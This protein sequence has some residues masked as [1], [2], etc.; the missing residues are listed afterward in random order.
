MLDIRLT[1][2]CADVAAWSLFRGSSRNHSIKD[3]KKAAE[4]LDKGKKVA[5]LVGA[6]ALPATD[7]MIAVASRLNASIANALLR[8]AAVPNDLPCVTGSLGLL[9]TKPSWGS[10]EEVRHLLH[11]RIGVSLR[12]VPAQA[13]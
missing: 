1:T 5:I 2:R 7:E 11:G 6:G 13:W 12:R 9:G 8:K 4:I 10:D 3:I